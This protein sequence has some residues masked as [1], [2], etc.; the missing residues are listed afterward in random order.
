MCC[1]PIGGFTGYV[2][3]ALIGVKLPEPPSR[4][5]SGPTIPG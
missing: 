1:M 2:H 3:L 4:V 5:R